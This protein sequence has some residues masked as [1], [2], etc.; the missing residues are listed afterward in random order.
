MYW[1]NLNLTFQN[2]E[3]ELVLRKKKSY[4]T[5]MFVQKQTILISFLIRWS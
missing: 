4:E 1:N 3:I 5:L 2:I